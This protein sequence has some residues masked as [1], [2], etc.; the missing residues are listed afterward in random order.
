[1]PAASNRL[2]LATFWAGVAAATLGLW[3]ASP[4]RLRPA[5][6]LPEGVQSAIIALELLR[7]RDRPHLPE[8]VD[9]PQMT[10]LGADAIGTRIRTTRERDHLL[11]S[12]RRDKYFIAAYDAFLTLVGVLQL[13]TPFGIPLIVAANLA[14]YYDVR[15]NQLLTG[16]LTG[17]ATPVPRDPSLKKWAFVFAAFLLMAP[18]LVPR[19]GAGFWRM[20]GLVGAIFALIG[21][22]E[23][24][25]AILYQNDQLLESAAGWLAVAFAFAALFFG[26]CRVLAHGLLAAFDRLAATRW[27]NWLSRWPA[28]EPTRDVTVPS[29]GRRRSNSR[30]P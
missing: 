20:L 15:E 2:S 25:L 9:P 10:V 11:R 23:G 18:A 5:R 4:G 19:R 16:V 28:S 14:A 13:R 3:T 26:T 22:I 12:V 27:L 29:N 30:V 21:S 7:E 1:M 24:L 6:P 17:A 8:F